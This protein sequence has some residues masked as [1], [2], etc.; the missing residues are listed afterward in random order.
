MGV[1]RLVHDDRV[2]N[3]RPLRN[4]LR[5]FVCDYNEARPHRAVNSTF[6]SQGRAHLLPV[7]C[8]CQPPYLG[9]LTPEYK[10]ETA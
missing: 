6:R 1:D 10:R 3:E 8:D 5:E 4:I 2:V 9:G 7:G